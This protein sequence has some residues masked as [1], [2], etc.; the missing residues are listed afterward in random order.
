MTASSA[1]MMHLGLRRGEACGLLD[2]D[3][4]LGHHQIVI[5]QT[6][7]TV[8][9]QTI[10]KPVKSPAAHRTLPLVLDANASPAHA[11]KRRGRRHPG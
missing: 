8:G 4:D 5:S 7:I 6:V 1:G 11:W 3:V 9:Y 2:R 10:V